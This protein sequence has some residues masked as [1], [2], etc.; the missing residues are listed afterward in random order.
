MESGAIL[1]SQITASSQWADISAAKNGRLHFQKT[2]STAGAWSAASNDANPW[3]QID[4]GGQYFRVTGVATQGRNEDDPQWVTTYKLQYSNDEVNF[5][6][7]IEQG[8]TTDKVNRHSGQMCSMHTRGSVSVSFPPK[9]VPKPNANI[10]N[11]FIESLFY[12]SS[13]L[14]CCCAVEMLGDISYV[15]KLLYNPRVNKVFTS[16]HFTFNPILRYLRKPER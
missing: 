7:Y 11:N 13:C 15:K 16:L 6:Y 1:N 2:D 12:W 5:Q 10:F 14:L 9:I 4:L 3:L 8:Q